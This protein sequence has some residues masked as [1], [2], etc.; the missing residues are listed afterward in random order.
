MKEKFCETRIFNQ[1]VTAIRNSD[2]FLEHISKYQGFYSPYS[3]S[4]MVTT[5]TF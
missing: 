3:L 5:R 4:V 1:D 2:P